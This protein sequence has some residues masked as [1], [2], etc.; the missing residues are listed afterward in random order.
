MRPVSSAT[1][2][3][4]SEGLVYAPAPTA[5]AAAPKESAPPDATKF[6]PAVHDDKSEERPLPA[7]GKWAGD[8]KTVKAE[9]E[10]LAKNPYRQGQDLG[11]A[12]ANLD[13]DKALVDHVCGKGC[14]C[15]KM[16]GGSSDDPLKS[17]EKR[18]AE[19]RQHEQD[20]H[21][22]AGEFASSGPELETVTASNGSSYAVGGKV[23]V[24]TTELAD[25]SKTVAKMEKLERAALKPAEPSDQDR[26]VAGEA[27][28][29]RAKAM[30]E[31][32][33][34]GA[35]PAHPPQG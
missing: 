32:S 15:S 31:M 9:Q 27:A 16:S 8:D 25:P 34:R 29:K 33:A 18:D 2:P 5:P 3:A 20:H 19:V 12:K 35:N 1:A 4:K 28:A 7:V 30:G 26:K 17:L 11:T 10:S 22:E 6:S 24:D 14:G 21:S 23:K 13:S